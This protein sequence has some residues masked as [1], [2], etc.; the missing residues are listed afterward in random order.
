[1][2]A[3]NQQINWENSVLGDWIRKHLM[4]NNPNFAA[5]SYT[6]PDYLRQN[7][8][9]SGLPA[10]SIGGDRKTPQMAQ[11]ES[12]TAYPQ[13]PDPAQVALRQQIA[14]SDALRNMTPEQV[15]AQKI[16][17]GRG[18][19]GSPE[20]GTPYPQFSPAQPPM[21]NST[22]NT[23]QAPGIAAARPQEVKYANSPEAA[24]VKT[25][26]QGKHFWLDKG[27]GSPLT[28]YYSKTGEKPNIP[29]SFAFEDPNYKPF[30]GL[31]GSGQ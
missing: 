1:M 31:F 19:M 12:G 8:S 16:L 28:P 11:P 27:D 21:V 13:Q 7:P 26:D 20:S 30:F 4:T 9:N 5:P 23:A 24:A 25:G 29:G 2:T 6:G 14:A 3:Y 15:M 22:P 17:A 18:Q 10:I